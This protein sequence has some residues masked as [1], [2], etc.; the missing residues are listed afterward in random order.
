MILVLILIL[1]RFLILRLHGSPT[2][3]VQVSLIVRRA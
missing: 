2:Q 1:I 3:A